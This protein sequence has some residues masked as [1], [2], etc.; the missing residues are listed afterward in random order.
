M[1]NSTEIGPAQSLEL[2]TRRAGGSDV[3]KVLDFGIV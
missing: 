3:V 2:L 1:T